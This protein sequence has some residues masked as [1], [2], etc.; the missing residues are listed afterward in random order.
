MTER[1]KQIEVRIKHI[2]NETAID[3]LKCNRAYKECVFVRP[4][5]VWKGAYYND[6]LVGVGGYAQKKRYVEI[7]VVFVK[8]EFRRQGIGSMINADLIM[9]IG[10]KMIIS[11]ARP[12]ESRIL[13]RFN[14]EK[15]QVLRNGTVKMVR[16]K[17][18][19]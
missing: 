14:F 7:C 8:A 15:T 4:A 1:T 6:V 3:F 19:E 13:D 10:N 9:E 16:R 11:Y 17:I 5:D 12:E 2:T 18:N